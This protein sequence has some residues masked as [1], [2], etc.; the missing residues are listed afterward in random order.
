VTPPVIA[1]ISIPA[2]NR[3]RYAF[4][5]IQAR[6]GGSANIA[7]PR[8]A[9]SVNL[10][11]PTALSL[12]ARRPSQGGWFKLKLSAETVDQIMLVREHGS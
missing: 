5:A 8:S 12:I 10:P 6:G 4:A 9:D 2:Q 1:V 11:H 7:A 3:F